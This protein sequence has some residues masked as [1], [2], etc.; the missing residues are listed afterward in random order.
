MLASKYIFKLPYLTF[1][2]YLKP[3]RNSIKNENT[4]LT[5]FPVFGFPFCSVLN[6]SCPPREHTLTETAVGFCTLQCL[7]LQLFRPSS[8]LNAGTQTGGQTGFG[9]KPRSADWFP[10]GACSTLLLLLLDR[11]ED[12]QRRTI[13]LRQNT[14]KAC[15]YVSVHIQLLWGDFTKA[16]GEVE[17]Y[18]RISEIK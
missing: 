3:W 6:L 1:K 8:D 17:H 2:I 5:A 13:S 15:L 18:L 4:W 10:A 16:H 9:L 14:D 7:T 11:E 12:T